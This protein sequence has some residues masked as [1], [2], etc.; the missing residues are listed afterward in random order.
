MRARLST[1]I[2]LVALVAVGAGCGGGGKKKA[3]AS[4]PTPT[5]PS[6]AAA[7]ARPKP[8]VHVPKG[9]PPKKLVI[10]DLIAG[11]GAAAKAGDP[12]TVNYV[13]VLYRG[14]KEFDASYG[15]SPFPFQLGAGQVIPGW[16][17]GIVGM[18]VGGRR[19]LI[20][21]PRDGY[22]SQGAPPDIPPNATLVFVVDLLSIG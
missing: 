10:K 6:P 7:P 12:V 13:G 21:P 2:V 16:D 18:R 11:K 19:E 17:K 8:T 1:A 5:A 3:A 22:G 4:A 9:P 14:G 20:I 15:R